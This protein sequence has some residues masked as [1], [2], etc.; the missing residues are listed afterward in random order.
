MQ[1]LVFGVFGEPAVMI[2]Q[3]AAMGINPVDMLL[4]LPKQAGI[5]AGGS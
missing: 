2:G 5:L 1:L 4:E 3:L